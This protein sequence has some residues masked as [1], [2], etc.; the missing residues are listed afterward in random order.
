MQNRYID[1]TFDFTMD[2]P[3]YWDSFWDDNP[4]LG[5]GGN[6]PDSMSKTLRQ[7]HK[8][9][10]SRML[11]NGE[12]MELVESKSAYLTW[13]GFRFGSDSITTS[14]R[15][16]NYSWMIANLEQHLLDYRCFMEHFIHQT[17]TIGG[18]II[19]PMHK[20]SI[21]Q[22]RGLNHQIKDRWDLTLE[23]IRKFYLDEWSPLYDDLNRD[24]P[25]FDLFVDFRGYIDFFFLQ[26]CVSA[27]YNSITFWYGNGDFKE[28]PLPQTIDDYLNWIDCQLAFVKKRNE[29]I[30]NFCC[31][32]SPD[33]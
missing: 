20:N 1:V 12:K 22:K 19:F 15:Y 27:D 5:A 4:I 29:R 23:C 7:Y 31:Q 2:T 9:L 10:W 11:S 14:F 3:K 24:K 32:N 6:D 13:K 26:D 18:S 28:N 30:K 33:N 21:N 17:Y 25:F 8:I 16:T